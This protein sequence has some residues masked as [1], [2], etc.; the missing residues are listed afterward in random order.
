LQIEPRVGQSQ[1]Q[2]NAAVVTLQFSPFE[3]GQVEGDQLVHRSDTGQQVAVD[4]DGDELR[5]P[6]VT[7][8][9]A[10]E[11]DAGLGRE[12]VLGLGEF[13]VRRR[14]RQFDRTEELA[15][16]IAGVAGQDVQALA[17]R[18]EDLTGQ[19][20][21]EDL[22]EVDVAAA[23]QEAL[24]ARVHQLHLAETIRTDIET[25]A[26]RSFGLPRQVLILQVRSSFECQE[27][28]S[29]RGSPFCPC[30]NGLLSSAQAAV[31]RR[32]LQSVKR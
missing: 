14:F 16:R 25:G 12:R 2:D 4:V 10:Q 30:L 19:E 31:E 3:A 15:V 20:A 6:A 11:V 5:Q 32:D 24:N 29:P 13:P 17:R 28:P 22:G 18:S 8:V 23:V 26:G 9:A 1:S 7:E 27:M 21:G